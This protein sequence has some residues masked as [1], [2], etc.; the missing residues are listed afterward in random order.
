[1]SPGNCNGMPA[2][3]LLLWSDA[4]TMAE[5]CIA[6]ETG[7]DV[8]GMAVLLDWEFGRAAGL[9][10]GTWFSSKNILI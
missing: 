9:A 10:D 2:T 4:V 3:L 5:D 1:M 8:M 6:M 7:G